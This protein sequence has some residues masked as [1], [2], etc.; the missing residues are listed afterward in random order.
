MCWRSALRETAFV[1]VAI[2]GPVVNSR[3]KVVRRIVFPGQ[4]HGFGDVDQL[5]TFAGQW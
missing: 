4:D 2:R 5:R 3:S 1:G